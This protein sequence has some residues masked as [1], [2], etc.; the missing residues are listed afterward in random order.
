MRK[1]DSESSS[2]DEDR[3]GKS[4]GFSGVHRLRRRVQSRP[5]KIVKSFRKRVMKEL[6]VRSSDQ[7]W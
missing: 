1:R 4:R 7:K 3:G 5:K 2:Q 6:S